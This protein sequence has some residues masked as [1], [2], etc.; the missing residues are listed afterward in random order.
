MEGFCRA[1]HI[2]YAAVAV[3]VLA[4]NN[5]SAVQARCLL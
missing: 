1:S 5:Y 2:Y 4:Y 3:H